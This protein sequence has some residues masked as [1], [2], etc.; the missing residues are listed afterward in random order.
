LLL[1]ARPLRIA[2]PG[3]L[4]H[5]T[6]RGNARQ[7]IFQGDGDRMLFLQVLE[8]ALSDGNAICHAYCLMTNHYYLLMQTP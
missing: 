7:S 3:A 1:T 5:L 6:A 4:Y 8:K 2:Y